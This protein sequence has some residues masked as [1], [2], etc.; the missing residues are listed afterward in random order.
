LANFT[1]KVN[2]SKLGKK[3]EKTF[4]PK[5]VEISR[6]P[7][8]VPSKPSKKILEKSKFHGKKDNILTF[9]TNNL[10][11]HI[12]AQASLMSVKKVLKMKENF[13][14]LSSKKIVEIHKTIN[15]LNK[16]K[17]YINITTKRPLQRQ[18][19]VLIRN[20]NISK[21]ILSMDNHILEN[22]N[23]KPKN[24]KSDIADFV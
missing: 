23:R 24:L 16:T 11:R 4:I 13:P 20:G 2:L 18:I 15:N 12:Y 14:N 5:L 10:N 3:S 6:L 17:P 22:I 7:P 9:N 19:I 1:F 8:P 21:V